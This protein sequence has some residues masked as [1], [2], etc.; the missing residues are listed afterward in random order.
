MISLLQWQVIQECFSLLRE[1]D[2]V[3]QVNVAL[4]DVPDPKNLEEQFRQLRYF[5]NGLFQRDCFAPPVCW[6]FLAPSFCSVDA[7][8][9][10]MRADGGRDFQLRYGSRWVDESAYR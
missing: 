7:L 5:E 1:I 10:D 2:D 8:S 9:T 4:P 3:Q 6:L